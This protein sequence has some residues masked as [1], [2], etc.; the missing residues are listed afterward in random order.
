MSNYEGT[1]RFCGRD[2][3]AGH[4]ENCPYFQ[5]K[6]PKVVKNPF[7]EFDGLD[8]RR[9]L[10]RL[11]SRLGDGLSFEAGNRRRARFLQSLLGASTNGFDGKPLRA[12][13]CSTVEAYHLLIAI[14]GALGVPIEVAARKLERLVANR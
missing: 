14:T 7:K 3:G 1:C 9:E 13:P 12:T 4:E 2:I 6:D 11:L 8:N 5:R 10:M